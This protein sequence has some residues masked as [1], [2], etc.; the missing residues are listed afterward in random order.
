[1]VDYKGEIWRRAH[2]GGERLPKCKGNATYTENRAKGR[3]GQVAHGYSTFLSH[4]VPSGELPKAKWK[5]QGLC[6]RAF[7]LM[8]GS[9]YHKSVDAV[10]RRVLQKDEEEDVLRECHSGVAGGQYIGEIM[11]RKVW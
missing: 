10:L 6:S 3:P 7:S 5:W 8:N 9:L 2:K 11:A 4:G 1:V